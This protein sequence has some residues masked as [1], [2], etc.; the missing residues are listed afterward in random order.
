VPGILKAADMGDILGLFAPRPVVVVAGRDDDIFPIGGVQEAFAQLQRIYTAAGAGDA[1]RLV[2]GA[3]G[4]RFYAAD[5]WPV[6]RNFI[7]GV[8]S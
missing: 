2:I 7:G 3:G 1:C 5:A 8:S 6:M 4:H